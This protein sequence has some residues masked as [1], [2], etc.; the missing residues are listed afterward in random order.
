[1]LLPTKFA[2][3]NGKHRKQTRGLRKIVENIHNPDFFVSSEP[4]VSFQ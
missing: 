4:Y 1:L 3:R 2:F